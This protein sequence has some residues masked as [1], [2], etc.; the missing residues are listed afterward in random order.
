MG[1]ANSLFIGVSGLNSFGNALG[2]VSDNVAN[3][4]T[5]GFKASSVTFGDMVAY[6]IGNNAASAKAQ[7]GQG[8]MIRDVSQV[9]SQ[10]SLIPTESNTDLAI[11]GAGFFVVDSPNDSRY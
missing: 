1:L 5:T 7:Q 11:A 4:N 10:G 9:F 3:A 6:A 2:V 8:S